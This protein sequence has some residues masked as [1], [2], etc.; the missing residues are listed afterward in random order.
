MNDSPEIK[1]DKSKL[2][3]GTSL[4][5]DAWKRIKKNKLAIIGGIVVI[6]MVLMAIFAPLLTPYRYEEQDMDDAF[7][8]PS[9]NHLLGTDQLGRDLLTRIMFGARISLMVGFVATVVS[10]VI[11]VSWG[12]IAG[13][14]GGKLDNFMMRFVDFMYS[15]PYMFLVILLMTFIGR[16]IIILFIALGCVQWLTMARIV[17][18]QVLSLKEKEFVEAARTCGAKNMRIIFL[19]IVPNLL[20]PVIVYATLTI[21]AVM[22]QEAF[23]SFI[24]LGVQPPDASWG[25]L[26]SDSI[27]VINPLKIYWWLVVF[28][29]AALAIT[30]FSLN[31]LG[32]GLRD[33]F[34]P[35]LKGR[36]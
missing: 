24:G 36:M 33:A 13:Y 6:L 35:Q 21:P 28:P 15:L 18:G 27:N 19:H 20:G 22:L 2:V 7:S 26:A 3:K 9:M 30:L 25:S 5:A 34:D 4:W 23:L 10:L 8:A 32:D 29:G 17:R 12:A 1:I 31:F 14:F 11:G 16:N